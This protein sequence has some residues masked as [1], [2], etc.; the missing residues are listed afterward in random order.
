MS[1]AAFDALAYRYDEL[2]TH[3]AVGRS[4]RRAVWRCVDA[5]FRAGDTVLD[6]GCGT[7]ADA[8]HFIRAG[9]D[10]RAV[11][12]SP[13]MVRIARRRGVDAAVLP[14]E[15][16]NAVEGSFDG[17]FSNF[18]ALNCVA[19]PAALRA[20]FARLVRPGGHLVLC[21]L[22]RVCAWETIGYLLQARP[23]KAFRRWSG[24]SCSASLGLRIAYPRARA[25]QRSFAPDFELLAWSGIGLAVPPSYIAGLPHSA[26]QF[27]S[28]LDR[29]L[30][31]RVGLRALADHRLFVFQRK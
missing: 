20:Q 31:H 17:V 10:V 29:H 4:Q 27:F 24:Q 18:G 21:I 7:G 11:D 8:L 3:S 6:V 19:D 26:V 12:S 1:T 15:N 2:W 13:E 14:A 16:L 22:G 25:F 30:A 28:M 9:I 5:L 23:R